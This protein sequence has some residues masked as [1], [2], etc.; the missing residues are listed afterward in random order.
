MATRRQSGQ[1]ATIIHPFLALVLALGML[2]GL[3][4]DSEGQTSPRP[5]NGPVIE[6]LR[7]STVML[8]RPAGDQRFN[9]HLTFNYRS[10][11]GVP[12]R[13]L[14]VSGKGPRGV[15]AQQTIDAATLGITGKNGSAR[16]T[17]GFTA[18]DDLGE[19][20]YT[21]NLVDAEGRASL[22][23]TTR[24][25]LIGTATPPIR[26]FDI[27]PSV[28]RPGDIITLRGRGL[29]PAPGEHVRVE[30]GSIPAK[31]RFEHP[32]LL[33]VIV[34]DRAPSSGPLR[35]TSD[36]GSVTTSIPF[37]RSDRPALHYDGPPACPAGY[38]PVSPWECPAIIAFLGLASPQTVTVTGGY[39]DTD[40]PVVLPSGG[41][42]GYMVD[43]ED[44]NWNGLPLFRHVEAPNGYGFPVA[45][46]PNEPAAI[47]FRA[48]TVTAS[49]ELRYAVVVYAYA[50][51]SGCSR[52][53]D[54]VSTGCQ[55][56]SATLLHVTVV[57]DP[58]PMP[59]RVSAVEIVA[60]PSPSHVA[61]GEFEVVTR[62]SVAQGAVTGDWSGWDE[63]RLEHVATVAPDGSRQS[64]REFHFGP[65]VTELHHH[66]RVLDRAPPGLT[67]I[68]FHLFDRVS[69]ADANLTVD[70][71]TA[72]VNGRIVNQPSGVILP[73]ER[74]S[75]DTE[76]FI[77]EW[78]N[79]AMFDVSYRNASITFEGSCFN[80]LVCHPRSTVAVHNG[81]VAVSTW[82]RSSVDNWTSHDHSP[83]EHF[84]TN[85]FFADVELSIL[86]G[87][88]VRHKPL[89]ARLR[90]HSQPR[91]D[92]GGSISPCGNE[93]C[94]GFPR[95]PPGTARQQTIQIINSGSED[96]SFTVSPA[97][98]P[99]HHSQSPGG[100]VGAVPSSA[101]G[102]GF[103][104][105][106]LPVTL[107]FDAPPAGAL[108]G[109]PCA[110]NA[111]DGTTVCERV[112]SVSSNDPD[113]PL[114]RIRLKGF[115][116]PPPHLAIE[117]DVA[118]GDVVDLGLV[119]VGQSAQREIRVVNRGGQFLDGDLPAA[120]PAGPGGFGFQP[121][122]RHFRLGA[123][124]ALPVTITAAP[125][126]RGL[127]EAPFE[128]W[129][130]EDSGDI[131]RR[132]TLRAITG[133]TLQVFDRS[134][135]GAGPDGRELAADDR[136]DL[137]LISL[138]AETFPNPSD[139]DQWV[140][141]SPVL[142][143][144]LLRNASA[145][146]VSLN[147][148]LS[149]LQVGQPPE[150]TIDGGRLFGPTT[151]LPN[152]V[153]DAGE[154]LPI[155]LHFD[156]QDDGLRTATLELR[157]DA[158]NLPST[159]T[160]TLAAE[161]VRP[162]GEADLELLDHRSEDNDRMIDFGQVPVNRSAGA[163]LAVRNTGQ[164]ESSLNVA[165]EWS[166]ATGPT[167]AASPS[168][169]TLHP[170]SGATL[171]LT[172]DSEHG[173]ILIVEF[174]PGDLGPFAADLTFT[175]NDPEQETI[176]YAVRGEG[177]R[178][179]VPA[180][181]PIAPVSEPLALG[182]AMAQSWNEFDA[183]LR[184]FL[185]EPGL[186]NWAS[187]AKHLVRHMSA[188]QKH[189]RALTHL[190]MLFADAQERANQS[191]FASVE[192]ENAGRPASEVVDVAATCRAQFETG[193]PPAD[194]VLR[195]SG[196]ITVLAQFKTLDSLFQPALWRAVEQE[197]NMPP[198]V[199]AGSTNGQP[200][201]LIGQSIAD[202]WMRVQARLHA[203]SQRTMDAEVEAYRVIAGAY[204]DFLAA[205]NAD[206]SGIAPA[207][208]FAGDTYGL[209][210]AGMQL[211][212]VARRRGDEAHALNGPVVQELLAQRQ[213][214]VL[215]AN[216]LLALHHQLVVQ[217]ILFDSMA[218]DFRATPAFTMQG[219]DGP[220]V[221]AANWPDFDTR[222]GIDPTT[223]PISPYSITAATAPPL[224]AVP[225]TLGGWIDSRIT[226]NR[227]WEN[228]ARTPLPG[229]G[230]SL[231]REDFEG[232]STPEVLGLFGESL[233]VSGTIAHFLHWPEPD[234]A[235][236]E[237]LLADAHNGADMVHAAHDALSAI[238]GLCAA[239]S[240]VG[241]LA[242]NHTLHFYGELCSTLGAG[243]EAASGNPFAILSVGTLFLQATIEVGSAMIDM[244]AYFTCWP[245]CIA[246]VT[247]A[248][249]IYR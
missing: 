74:F 72:D 34:P 62:W 221:F 118:A 32:N 223:V 212:A 117:G 191:C 9:E 244:Q 123:G 220:Q 40:I 245:N 95:T 33:S 87:E 105:N 164:P 96:L 166:A 4:V 93:L 230:P 57:P 112:I 226:D 84:S 12:I 3:W 199:V 89:V 21:L 148:E 17:M 189:L 79:P 211:Y 106:E 65:G 56:V 181:I 124:E 51:D 155:T 229:G 55:P 165:P 232:L 64:S 8:A 113:N 126:A 45:F 138:G 46:Q 128:I 176:T 246:P 41:G 115:V 31:L 240:L 119:P 131:H 111:A 90:V 6:A 210:A 81:W 92:F 190:M 187:Y 222:M 177:V 15:R 192:A 149:L 188:E 195:E 120:L 198:Y 145:Q 26:L 249:W 7:A 108:P 43:V 50:A 243:V 136:I 114:V 22:A 202:N 216:Q 69:P 183:A 53:A 75:I 20:T 63:H 77:P 66:F 28:G 116:D 82:F 143:T 156:P 5:G 133:P 217:A 30:F 247:L 180:L 236:V 35:I 144:L 159:M 162:P 13:S 122:T 25:S 68:R 24:F 135:L 103:Y 196:L 147:V 104:Y 52:V 125:S 47:R 154:A 102:Q 218:D 19:Y 152:L 86:D 200:Q 205:S 158:G 39:T 85:T 161:A 171:P 110:T 193:L 175:T 163:Q 237:H 18:Q 91:L 38:Q 29:E 234:P 54:I 208:N 121:S 130:Y 150:W 231:Q 99:F 107:A 60:P 174:R 127:H 153:L 141:G 139:P 80:N 14:I 241:A 146:A 179:R 58:T 78:I 225:G 48:E 142:R 185:G 132:L 184:D 1:L 61:P 101:L 137:G 98:S 16:Y 167:G 42:A 194:H 204:R 44:L 100:W 49:V 151:T 201:G 228:P 209:I 109:A 172:L 233:H 169:F 37:L 239:A 242:H 197:T 219:P 227:L 88:G 10:R 59:T 2:F 71:D 224:L 73:N 207:A 11:D 215:R 67:A 173:D 129:A 160:V 70:V 157:S 168:P 235:L 83:E 170:F 248:E 134:V 186:S 97:D 214:L 76:W 206:P 213:A 94:V 238:N 203:L 23:A 36:R 182:D 27:A 140:V 178:Y